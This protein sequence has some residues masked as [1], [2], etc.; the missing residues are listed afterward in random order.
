MKNAKSD[1]PKLACWLLL[2]NE[3]LAGDLVESFGAGKSRGWFWRQVLLAIA[4]NHWPQFCYAIAGTVMPL[5]LWHVVDAAG[6]RIPSW[7]LLPWPWS[8]LVFELM[9]PQILAV[10]AL[11]VLAIG[12]KINGVFRWTGLLR[13]GI[14]TWVLIACTHYLPDIFPAIL[15]PG[16][17]RGLLLPDALLMLVQ[18]CTFLVSAW[19]GCA[20]RRSV[21]LA[22]RVHP[23]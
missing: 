15:R 7:Y 11:P 13:T 5:F 23:R 17:H 14:I 9:N 18:C 6:P 21:S 12:L 20:S 8:Q 22:I 2:H 1:P 19:L 4:V 10:L 3:A 16:E